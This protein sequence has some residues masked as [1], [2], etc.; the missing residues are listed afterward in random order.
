MPL[1]WIFFHLHMCCNTH[2]VS[3]CQWKDACREK[4]S[5][6]LTSTL[7]HVLPQPWLSSTRD[8]AKK[9]C[10]FHFTALLNSISIHHALSKLNARCLPLDS[11]TMSWLS[12]ACQNSM[13][14]AWTVQSNRSLHAQPIAASCWSHTEPTACQSIAST[15]NVP[16]QKISA[17]FCNVFLKSCTSIQW[18]ISTSNANQKAD[19]T[20]KK[21]GQ[22]TTPKCNG[23]NSQL[24][25]GRREWICPPVGHILSHFVKIF[26]RICLAQ[27][28]HP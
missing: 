14:S 17:D 27:I 9:V 10:Y 28:W 12:W 18:R 25:L 13:A 20:R 3:I 7:I 15:E 1:S 19:H 23:Y 11:S 26:G 5:F 24:V 2:I 6:L 8:T 21:R 22:K 16:H 4:L